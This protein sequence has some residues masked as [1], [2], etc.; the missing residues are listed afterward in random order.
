MTGDI[1]PFPNCCGCCFPNGWRRLGQVAQR[2]VVEEDGITVALY[3][4]LVETVAKLD[5][6]TG[7]GEVDFRAKIDAVLARARG[8]I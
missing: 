4:A 3:A 2:P 6:Y 7:R 1:P 5:I 8:D